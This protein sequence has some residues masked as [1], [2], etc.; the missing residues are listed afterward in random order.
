MKNWLTTV[1]CIP[2][3]W[4]EAFLT[5]FFSSPYF[6]PKNIL[7]PKFFQRYVFRLWCNLHEQVCL[8]GRL[9]V[10]LDWNQNCDW[11][12]HQF[13]A[14]VLASQ[15]YVAYICTLSTFYNMAK[16]HSKKIS[17]QATDETTVQSSVQ[18][19][20]THSCLKIPPFECHRVLPAHATNK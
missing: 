5:K 7:Y 4:H 1:I 16:Q 11:L 3:F 19:M 13:L 14:V 12:R 15:S 18:Y 17:T 8:Y 20:C 2:D 6:L 9:V 10:W